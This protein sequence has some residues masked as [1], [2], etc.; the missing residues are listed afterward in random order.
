MK[1]KLKVFSIVVLTPVFALT[2]GVGF[3][4]QNAQ[5]DFL[6]SNVTL[7]NGE[8]IVD[9]TSVL[10]EDGKIAKIQQNIVG[11][12]EIIDGAGKF[13]MPAMTNS[14]THVWARENCRPTRGGKGGRV[15][16]AGY[17]FV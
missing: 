13:L 16:Y 10:V 17:A 2:G 8:E 5:D 11:D 6:I 14:H 7:F 3:S 12:Y 15:K 9:N 1:L 4:E